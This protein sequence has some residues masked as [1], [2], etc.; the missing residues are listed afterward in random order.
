[1]NKIT[2]IY[3]RIFI[4]TTLYPI[5]T[6]LIFIGIL[7]I[8]QV[9]FCNIVIAEDKRTAYEQMNDPTWIES[10]DGWVRYNNDNTRTYIHNGNYVTVKVNGGFV[11][12]LL[13]LRSGE[14]SGVPDGHKVIIASGC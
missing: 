8:I 5:I 6:Y 13:E 1:M 14:L 7:F 4:T 9:Y 12:G 3:K 10:K 2:N 11:V